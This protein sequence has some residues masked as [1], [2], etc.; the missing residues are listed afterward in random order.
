MTHNLQQPSIVDSPNS[1]SIYVSIEIRVTLLPLTVCG[2]LFVRRMRYRLGV[3]TQRKP[4]GNAEGI[5]GSSLA[6]KKAQQL[7]SSIY[8]QTRP[9]FV[10][11][12]FIVMCCHFQSAG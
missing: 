7:L 9:A 12:Y 6:L 4:T 3:N 2:I 11:L 10:R 8:F 5:R 1:Y